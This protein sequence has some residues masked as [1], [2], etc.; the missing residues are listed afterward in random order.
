MK[1]L[2]YGHPK[3]GTTILFYKIQKAFEKRFPGKNLQTV[4]EPDRLEDKA[5]GQFLSIQDAYREPVGEHLLAKALIPINKG[6]GFSFESAKSL[7][8]EKKI[9]I[10]RDPRDRW[11]SALFYRWFRKC[12]E[13]PEEYKNVIQL[14]QFKEQ[15]PS[16]LPIYALLT[17]N[18]KRLEKHIGIQQRI[19][20]EYAQ[21]LQYAKANNWFLLK[22]E[23]LVEGK[24]EALNTYLDLEVGEGEV[25]KTYQRVARSKKAGNWREWFTRED[26]PYFQ[27]M[28]GPF[29]KDM[30]YN[31]NDWNLTPVD[32]I[33]PSQGSDYLMK[34]GKEKKNQKAPKYKKA[35]HKLFGN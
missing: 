11:I 35:W 1:I 18:R 10:I 3:T 12:D 2:I 25:S 7:A 33:D 23:D 19:M 26:V 31:E 17:L 8:A 29:L 34:L 5:D 13:A 14:T 32:H 21:I 16:A 20:N 4:F 28:F 27:E 22:Y 15:H 6:V 30:G 24:F 9:L